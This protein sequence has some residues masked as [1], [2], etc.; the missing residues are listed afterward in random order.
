MSP[1]CQNLREALLDRADGRAT[2]EENRTVELHLQGC[3]AC[4]T[5]A[6]R[7]GAGDRAF[8]LGRVE[9]PAPLLAEMR[10]DLLRRLDSLPPED[11]AAHGW[12]GWLFGG[13]VAI[14]K[15]FA[16]AAVVLLLTFWAGRPP[17]PVPA[18]TR[19]L[20]PPPPVLMDGVDR[21]GLSG[22]IAQG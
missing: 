11:R 7:L 3:P 16:W 4:R 17:A 12:F 1:D 21:L 19:T 5:L 18:A 9:V 13:S 10:V 15:P 20:P 2:P 22:S 14:P 8:A 6:D